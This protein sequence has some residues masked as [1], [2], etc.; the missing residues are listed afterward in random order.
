MVT[1]G[2]E[3]IVLFDP[4][5]VLDLM[6]VDMVDGTEDVVEGMEAGIEGTGVGVDET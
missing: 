3:V 6:I 1:G 2:L 4:S 5:C